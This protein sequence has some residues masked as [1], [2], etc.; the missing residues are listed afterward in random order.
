MTIIERLH[1]DLS[2]DLNRIAR[3]FRTRVKLTLVVRQPDVEGDAGIV[4][5]NDDYELAIAEIRRQEQTGTVTG[6]TPPARGPEGR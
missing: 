6:S 5:G 3:R 1:D 4:I 2:D